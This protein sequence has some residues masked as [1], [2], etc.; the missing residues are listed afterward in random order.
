MG[1][2][3]V[4]Q[5]GFT[6]V[7][8]T[9]SLV[10]MSMMIVALFGLFISLVRSTV[11]AK[12]RAVANSLATNQM[13][14]LKSLPYDNLAVIGGSIIAPVLLPNSKTETVN[15]VRYTI[16][17]SISYAD[18][19]YDGCGPY[20]DLDTKTK[21]CRNYPPPTGAPVTDSNPADYK[22]V[23]VAVSDVSNARL[24]TVDT[25]ISARVSETASNTG[26]LFVT[27]TDPSGTPLSGVDVSLANTTTTPAVNVADSTDSNG[28]AIF[29][30]MPPDG[31]VDYVVTAGKSGYSTLTTIGANGSLQPVYPRQTVLAQQASYLTM[32]LAKMSSNSLIV[33]TTNTVGTPIPGVRVYIKGGYKKYTLATD[34]AYYYDN[35]TPSDLRPVTGADG[36]AAVENLVPI[37][38]YLFC[39]DLGATNCRVG[40]TT[41]YLAAAV[42]YWGSNPLNPITIPEDGAAPASPGFE[43]GG[44][45]YLQKV[46]LML[47]TNSAFPRVFSVTPGSI[48]TS[49]GSLSNIDVAVEGVNLSGASLTFKQGST[50]FSGSGCTGSDTQRTCQFNLTGVSQGIPLQLTVTTAAGT[51][52]LPTAPLGGIDVSS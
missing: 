50:D 20:P 40:G 24:A 2:H 4:G 15:G 3:R 43:Y 42:P 46:R 27:V 9:V 35:F 33:E 39:G 32:T 48:S 13:E 28:L 19:S 49:A 7:E 23:S 14:Y 1:K 8:L 16:K 22:T 38:K 18:D 51:L 37:N 44:Q 12:R 5:A 26:A 21:Y 31:G 45:S 6:L 41:Y 30:G 36:I 25:Q 10:V 29:Y 17:T 34:T 11:I 47:T 52:T